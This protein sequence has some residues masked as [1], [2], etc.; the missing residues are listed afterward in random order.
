MQKYLH[1]SGIL[2]RR[3]WSG[4]VCKELFGPSSDLFCEVEEGSGAVFPNSKLPINSKRKQMLKFA[5]K[6][7]GKVLYEGAWGVNYS[8]YLP[9]RLAKSFLASVAGLRVN[10]RHFAQD[11]P[12]LYTAKIRL[13]E[14]ENVDDLGLDDL[15][16]AEEVHCDNGNVKIVD[17][18]PNGRNVKV[19][20]SNKLQYL[21]LLAQ[22]RLCISIKEHVECF[23]EGM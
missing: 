13:I 4:L 9:I 2:Q 12:E 16:F 10:F 18:K 5:G 21:D 3:E 20:E 14:N 7:V 23:M 22:Y 17:L 8:Q 11:A 15:V 19:T 1:N 6:F